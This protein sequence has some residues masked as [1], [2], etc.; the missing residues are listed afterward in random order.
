MDNLLLFPLGGSCKLRYSIDRYYNTENRE[1]NFF[2]W[3]LTNFDSILYF[4]KNIDVEIRH[5][6]FYDSN[7]SIYDNRIVNHNLTRY[8][9]V[10][11]FPVNVTFEQQMPEFIEKINRRRIRLKNHILGVQK[12]N[13]VHVLDEDTEYNFKCNSSLSQSNLFIPSIESVQECINCI[14]NINANLIFRLNFLIPP[15]ATQNDVMLIEQLKNIEHVDIYYLTKDDNIEPFL[16]QCRHWSWTNAY[17]QIKNKKLEKKLLPCNF[18]VIIYKKLNKDL[19][20]MNDQDAINHYINHG[21]YE[22]RPYKE[23]EE[24]EVKNGNLP[25]DFN[26][27]IYK[28][29]NKDLEHMNDQDAI[30][31]YINHGSHEKRKYN[32]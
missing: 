6:Q 17:C 20:H 4:I 29:L 3:V 14:Q 19:A 13:F 27:T 10:H 21:S 32:N 24:L 5:N 11:D 2:D 16:Y 22:K 28:K 1:T 7:I 25:H 8:S 31:H 30:N 12:I 18:N 26:V 15:S 9:S 23:V